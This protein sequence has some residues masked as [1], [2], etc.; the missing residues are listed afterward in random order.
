MPNKK[1]YI[2]VKAITIF[3]VGTEDFPGPDR[4]AVWDVDMKAHVNIYNNASYAQAEADTLNEI[5]RKLRG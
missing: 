5:E 4:W 1:R 3:E 2:V